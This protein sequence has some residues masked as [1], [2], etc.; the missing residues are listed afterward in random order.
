MMSPPSSP[1]PYHVNTF[2][3]PRITWHPHS[4][5]S[6]PLPSHHSKIQRQGMVLLLCWSTLQ[7]FEC[8]EAGE[9]SGDWALYFRS[10]SQLQQF[11]AALAH[12]WQLSTQVRY[13]LYQNYF[14]EKT[15]MVYLVYDMTGNATVVNLYKETCPTLD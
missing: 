4:A 9:I 12:T 3:Y 2:S 14:K 8:S 15:L 13:Q 1:P 6:L 5:P 10:G 11:V 7:E